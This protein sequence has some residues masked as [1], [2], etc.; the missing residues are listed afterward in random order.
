MPKL[1]FSTDTDS[2]TI[3]VLD[4]EDVKM[5]PIGKI[6]VGNGPRG[7]VRFTKEGRGFVT[8]HAGNTV[9]EIDAKSLRE[10]GRITVGIAPIGL[11]IVP[12]D[13][14]AVVSNAGDNTVSVIDLRSREEV[15]TLSVGREPRHPD[16]TPDGKHAF[17]PISGSDYVSMVDISELLSDSPDFEAV[18]EVKRIQ[19]GPDTMPYSAAVSPNG[20]IVVAANNQTSYVTII[21]AVKGVAKKEVDV[22]SKGARGTA[23]SPDS[24]I[25]YVSIEDTSEVVAIDLK[26]SAV[27]RRLDTGPGPRGLL[28]DALS[29]TIILSAFARTG[30]KPNRVA[31]SATVLSVGPSPLAAKAATPKIRDVPVGAGPCSVSIYEY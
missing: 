15:T 3:T 24:L 23:Y 6:P 18:R 12:G 19:T 11:A 9:S 10:V 7:A 17:V 1:L 22:G 13:R 21:D 5:E 2:G 29:D 14:F 28:Y 8:N 25:A 20:R 26:K 16:I 31:N 27:A 4:A 30:T